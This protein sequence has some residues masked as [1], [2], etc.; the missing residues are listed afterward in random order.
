MEGLE[1]VVNERANRLSI[2]PECSDSMVRG[3]MRL[4]LSLHATNISVHPI[5]QLRRLCG[6]DVTRDPLIPLNGDVPTGPVW[7]EVKL[8]AHLHPHHHYRFQYLSYFQIK[9][10]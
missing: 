7:G 8:H 6:R 9:L 1:R 4:Q 3:W 2:N 5:T 10:I